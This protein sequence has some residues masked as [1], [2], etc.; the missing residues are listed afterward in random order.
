MSTPAEIETAADPL[1]SEEKEQ[2][3]R[4]LALRLRKERAE[5]SPRIF[6]D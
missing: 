4:F 2:L 6:S 3:L 1:S 5:C